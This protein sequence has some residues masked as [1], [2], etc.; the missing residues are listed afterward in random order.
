M[1]L[2]NLLLPP[3]SL[4][5]L[6]YSSELVSNVC[7]HPVRIIGMFSCQLHLFDHYKDVS[8]F[9]IT[10]MVFSSTGL[11]FYRMPFNLCFP[12][13][14]FLLKILK[15]IWHITSW[16]YKLYTCWFD[17]FKYHNMVAIVARKRVYRNFCHIFATFY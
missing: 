13:I 6:T 8:F 1:C 9:V 4:I 3:T 12:D 17:I 15:Y 7:R 10:L 11:A 2:I 14:F 16:K 5:P